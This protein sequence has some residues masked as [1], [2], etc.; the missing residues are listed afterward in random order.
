MLF[1]GAQRRLRTVTESREGVGAPSLLSS[2]LP[3]F[4]F[5]SRLYTHS[6]LFSS[7]CIEPDPLLCRSTSATNCRGFALSVAHSR[8]A[9]LQEL[10]RIVTLAT[11]ASWALLHPVTSLQTTPWTEPVYCLRKPYSAYCRA[12]TFC[13]FRPCREF[14]PLQQELPTI[15]HTPYLLHSDQER[16]VLDEQMKQSNQRIQNRSGG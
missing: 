5:D 13:F 14:R 2:C 6:S 12:Q 15:G 11:M 7:S 10:L 9:F 3:H 8:S 4:V 1:Q 16:C